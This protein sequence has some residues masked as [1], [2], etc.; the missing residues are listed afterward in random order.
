MTFNELGL[1]SEI[2]RAVEDLGFSTPT[3][4]QQQAIPAIMQGTTDLV[5]LAQT[6]TGKTA[7]FGLPLLNL[8]DE[9]VSITQGIVVCP[10]R[11]LC[12]QITNDLKNFSKYVRNINVVA[13]YGGASIQNQEKEIRRGAQIL[14]ATPGRMIDLINRRVIKLGEVKYVVLDE[15]DEM[16][17]MGFQEDIDDILSHT[18]AQKHVWLFSATMPKEVAQISKKYLTDPVELTVGKKNMSAENITHK[19]FAVKEKD[20]YAGLKRLIDYYPEIFGLIF[21]RTKRETQDIAEKLIKD[22]YNCESL[23]GD[24]SQ[25][26]RDTVM[27][28]FRERTI[29]ILCA[30]DVAARGIDVN[31]ITHVINYN[32]PD[33]VENYTHR[34]GR[35]AR[36]G[37]TGYSLVLVNTRE[38]QRIRE[39]E[40]I[41]S[42]KFEVGRIPN[43]P[44]I[45]DK[46]L[47]ALLDKLSNQEV[48]EK[49]IAPYIESAL[50]K[51]SALSK[52][53]VIKKFISTEFNRFLEYYRGAGDLNADARVQH[54][55]QGE[56]SGKRRHADADGEYQRFFVNI[57]GA[58]G[59]NKGALLRKICDAGNVSSNEVGRI[60]MRDEFSFFEVKTEIARHIFES[61]KGIEWEGKRLRIEIAEKRDSGS[62]G[63]YK[64]GNRGG[65]GY[66]GGKP[67]S[68]GSRKSYG[69]D[70]GGFNKNKNY[71]GGKDRDFG[72]KKKYTATWD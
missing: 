4:I 20:R 40:R 11:E 71:G 9:H 29:Q 68:F 34:S 51:L 46:Q 42:K 67:R 15:A 52:E 39:I 69:G 16:L 14:V 6:G 19:Y 8:I 31:D 43:G 50:E 72:G 58:N 44:E 60:D 30:T 12:L 13:V 55:E 10:T 48:N 28:K 25:A 18:P 63:G 2:L 49:E 59:I 24:L 23:H 65:G 56:S 61:F 41:I 22:G 7:A 47:M 64:G 36:A 27:K 53:E 3:P 35:T 17:N 45:C 26:Q 66:G 1:R 62:G 54:R 70:R 37:K 5:G 21:C 33:D 32:L 57:G 38:T